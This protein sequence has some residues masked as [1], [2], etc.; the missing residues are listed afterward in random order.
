[1]ENRATVIGVSVFVALASGGLGWWLGSRVS[2]GGDDVKDFH[3]EA[4]VRVPE[5]AAILVSFD[6]AFAIDRLI[7]ENG[8][9]FPG[10]NGD[11]V[12]EELAGLSEE[13]LGVDLLKAER[14]LF[15]V[16]PKKNAQAVWLEGDF[17]GELEGEGKNR[18]HQ[19][20]EMYKIDEGVWAASLEG[21]IVIGNKRGVKWTIDVAEGERDPLS[22]TDIGAFHT[23]ALDRVDDGPFVVS[24]YLEDLVSRNKEL[25]GLEAAAA[26]FGSDGDYSL[27][28]LGEEEVLEKGIELFE[29]NQDDLI[30]EL[31]KGL[32]KAERRSN[33][34]AIVALT[35]LKYKAEDLQSLFTYEHSGDAITAEGTAG[36]FAAAYLAVAAVV[37]VPA[38]I[39]YMRRAKTTEAI[40]Q[41]DK[42]YKS[43]SNYYTAPRVARGTGAKIDCQ[44]PRSQRLTPDVRNLNCCGGKLDRD[45]DNRCDVDT[46]Q[47][48]TA[49]W[50]ALNF[51]MNDQHYFGYAFESSGTLAAAK[52]TARAHA[53]LDCDGTLST[54]ERYGYGDETASHAECSMKGSSAFYKNNETE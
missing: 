17:D 48:T 18:E 39:K 21:G 47:W 37:A 40:D 9:L 29:E 8:G 36:G 25:E 42:M 14:G 16:A 45:N 31:E 52:F 11:E 27:V 26:S 35:L 34:E 54:F 22:E 3:I 44:F 13:H 41:L 10:K 2:M 33:A 49:T 46:T 5:E 23:D 6:M 7:D 43:A 15:W 53:D 38:F 12:R 19:G 51:Q 4:M 20:V 28:I 32:E 24:M 1:M 30:S 50:S